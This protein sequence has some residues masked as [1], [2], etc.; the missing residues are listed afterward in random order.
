MWGRVGQI[1]QSKEGWWG[2][3]GKAKPR[4]DLGV[5]RLGVARRGVAR[6]GVTR[7]G[8]ARRVV[9]RR[10]RARLSFVQ[11]L[12]CLLRAESVAWENGSSREE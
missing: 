5:A 7:R 12:Q 8:V 2:R 10:D 6:R 11:R 4:T 9:S 3:L 1:M